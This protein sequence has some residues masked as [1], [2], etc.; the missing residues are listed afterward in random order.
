V[1]SNTFEIEI[2]EYGLCVVGIGIIPIHFGFEDGLCGLF[3]FDHLD[4]EK[5]ISRGEVVRIFE[6]TATDEE[7]EFLFVVVTG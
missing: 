3:L 5:R 4:G 7:L 6:V 2:D 1:S